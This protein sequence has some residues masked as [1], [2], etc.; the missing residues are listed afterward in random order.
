MLN[1]NLNTQIDLSNFLIKCFAFSKN[2]KALN[3]KWTNLSSRTKQKICKKINLVVIQYSLVTRESLDSS[4]LNSSFWLDKNCI[5]D[6]G[7]YGIKHRQNFTKQNF[8]DWMLDNF[9]LQ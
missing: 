6:Y 9:S 8:P 3:Q 4:E 5:V 2:D 7:S 1:F